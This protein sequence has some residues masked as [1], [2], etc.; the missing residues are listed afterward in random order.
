ML[1]INDLDKLKQLQMYFSWG[2]QSQ[3]HTVTVSANVLNFYSING[4][5]LTYTVSFDELENTTSRQ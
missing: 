1:E 2:E 5:S 4:R 3:T